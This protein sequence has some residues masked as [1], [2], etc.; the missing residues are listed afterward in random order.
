MAKVA[1]SFVIKL[2]PRKRIFIRVDTLPEI[3]DDLKWLYNEVLTR[4]KMYAH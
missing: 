3:K 2:N 1:N 4:G